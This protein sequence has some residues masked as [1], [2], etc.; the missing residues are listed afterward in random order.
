LTHDT[1]RVELLDVFDEVGRHVG[2]KD[3]AAVHRDGDWHRVFHCLVVAERP[4]PGAVAVLQLRGATKAA[5][6][7]M[8]DLTAAG[9][10]EAGESPLEGI[11]ELEEELGIHVDPADL[12]ALGT[13]RLIDE[14]GEGRLNRELTYVYLLHDDRPLADYSPAADEVDGLLDVPIDGLLELFDSDGTLEVSGIAVAD[15][16]TTSPI[17][18]TIGEADL[19]PNRG[20]WVT[21][22]V[23]AQRYL[24]GERPLAI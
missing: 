5:F 18:R 17:R 8:L 11:R 14:S 19:V 21:L 2:V 3:R 24:A 12:V 13:R 23:M 22:L 9:H 7:A 1:R 15:D 20:Y 16:G 10:L 4:G 6:A